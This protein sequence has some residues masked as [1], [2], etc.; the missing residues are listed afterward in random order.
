MFPESLKLNC[1]LACA[2]YQA[3][4]VKAERERTRRPEPIGMARGT[5]HP[6]ATLQRSATA[7][8]HRLTRRRDHPG[9]STTVAP[10]PIDIEPK[11]TDAV[12]LG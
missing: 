3:Q 5:G 1:E 12:P 8:V 4:L 10:L 9:T 2:E 7:V 6:V 11:A